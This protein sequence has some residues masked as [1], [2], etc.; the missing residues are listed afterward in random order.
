MRT[1]SSSIAR[2]AS[3]NDDAL[4][5]DDDLFP[6]TDDDANDTPAATDPATP[7]QTTTPPSEPSP[8]SSPASSSSYLD[9]YE[10]GI[11]PNTRT[12]T[13]GEAVTLLGMF[14]TELPTYCVYLL[15]HRTHLLVSVAILFLVIGI[16]LHTLLDTSDA[17]ERVGKA[18]RGRTK[19]V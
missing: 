15:F 4:D 9:G 1:R 6:D 16:L 5:D 11:D 12:P 2:T 14:L 7:T 18:V 17:G 19:W 3:D 13:F 10:D 8:S